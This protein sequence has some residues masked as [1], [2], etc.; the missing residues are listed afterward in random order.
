MQ[1][2]MK[3]LTP[4]AI[5]SVLLLASAAG[6][7][8]EK[9]DVMELLRV[10]QKNYDL[11]QDYTATFHKQQRVGGTLHD[12]EKIFVKFKKPFMIYMK[13][14]GGGENGREVLYVKG[15]H[16][17]KLLAHLGGMINYL[18]PTFSLHPR[19]RIAMRRNLRPITESGMGNTIKLLLE[20]CEKARKNNDLEVVYRGEGEVGERRTLKF[21]RLLPQKEGY[22]AHRTLIELDAETKFPLS[23]TSYG[24]KGE[25]LEKYRY[26]DLKPDV[27]LTESDFDRGNRE[28]G[29]GYIV[30]PVPPDM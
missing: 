4:A 5:L 24:W 16:N 13:W 10:A 8:R 25:L 19:G 21:E 11:L 26:I 20:V 27:G 12:E 30:V 2:R 6:G 18:A 9:L 15:K 22:P 7:A 23:V 14:T 3:Q 28:Y 17:D 29:F 1:R